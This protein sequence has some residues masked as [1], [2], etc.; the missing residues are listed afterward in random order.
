VEND[1]L[2]WTFFSFKIKFE[3]INL[4]TYYIGTKQILLNKTRTKLMQSVHKV[5]KSSGG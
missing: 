2:I 5:R 3:G 4:F 1:I